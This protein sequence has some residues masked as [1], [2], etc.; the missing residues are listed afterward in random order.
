MKKKALVLLSLLL[1]ATCLAGCASTASNTPATTSQ[2]TTSTPATTG[3]TEFPTMTIKVGH[4]VSTDHGYHKGLEKFKEIVEEKTGGKVTVEIYPSSSL[5]SE[6]EMIEGLQ[7]G[8][9]D[10]CLAATSQLTSFLP[11]YQVFDLPYI[12]TSRDEAW[13]TLDGELGQEMLDKLQEKGIVGLSYFEV[14]FRDF[15]NNKHPIN[16]PADLSGM[17]FRTMET[18]VH[19][20]AVGYWGAN[21]VSMPIGEVYTALQTGTIDGQENPLSIILSQKLYEV[22]KYIS[23]TEHF[24]TATPLLVSKTFWDSMSPELQKIIQDAAYSGR[25]VCRQANLA[26]EDKAISVFKD[27][28]CE[29]NNADKDAFKATTADIYAMF[30]DEIGQDLIDK[31][32]SA[33]KNY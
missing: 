11:E 15:T 18:P 5:G 14:G 25:D 13:D 4:S 8:T 24:Y 12:F 21:A 1:V 30:S 20:K 31:F 16:T 9:V 17:K 26:A 3:T 2:N 7:L 6:R 22:Q 32:V 29:I 23:I 19:V 27:A 28:G 10:M 33:A